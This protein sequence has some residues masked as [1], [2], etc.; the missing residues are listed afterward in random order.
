[1]SLQF[2][3][4]FSVGGDR[5]MAGKMFSLHSPRNDVVNKECSAKLA[6]AI[7]SDSPDCAARCGSGG[8]MSG[9]GCRHTGRCL[10]VLRGEWEIH[11]IEPGNVHA[12]QR[13]GNVRSVRSLYP[14]LS[15]RSTS[16][17]LTVT[18]VNRRVHSQPGQ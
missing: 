14:G 16:R 17:V 18:A 2:W 10:G 1:M 7:S 5:E 15:R 12:Q 13:R 3:T 9:E 4:P 8:E 6:L 11:R